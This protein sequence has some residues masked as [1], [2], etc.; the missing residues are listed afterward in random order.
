[1]AAL[2]FTRKAALMRIGT[3]TMTA[4]KNKPAAA[5]DHPEHLAERVRQLET[6]LRKS[7]RSLAD[8]LEREENYRTLFDSSNEAMVVFDPASEK[9]I[10]FTSQALRL[11][12]Y[13]PQEMLGRTM[14]DLLSGQPPCRQDCPRDG[15]CCISDEKPLIFETC[16]GRKNGDPL[17]LEVRLKRCLINRKNSL[18]MLLR[19]IGQRKQT[20]K[21]LRDSE[22]RYRTAFE[23]TG[24]AMFINEADMTLSM[25][26]SGFAKLTGYFKHE[27][28]GRM[29]WTQFV[30]PDDVRRLK[31]YHVNR[32]RNGDA[33]NELTCKLVDRQGNVKDMFLKVDLI[34]GT[35]RSIGSF[36]DITRIKQTEAILQDKEAQLRAILDSFDGL[37][38]VSSAD[39]RL[40]YINPGY[41]NLLGR[42]AT[43]ERCYR[44]LHGRDGVCPFCVQDQVQAGDTVSFE[45]HN[46]FDKRWYHS[47]NSPI[48]RVDGSL[49]LLALVTDINDRKEAEMALQ[50][51]A[52][53]LRKENTM[54]RSCIKERY[55]LGRIIGKSK[56]MQAVYEQIINA[57]ATNAN[58]IIYGE[59]GT[60]KELVARAIHDLSDRHDRSFVPVNS[61]AIPEKLL[62]S[63]FFG[64]KQGAFTGAVNDKPGY[65]DLADGG[66]LFLDELGEIELNLQV[67]L[68]RALESGVYTPVGDRFERKSDMRIIA[69]TNQDLQALV[70]RGRM[71]EDF[72]Y[73]INVIPIP[74]PP[75]RRRKD[76]LPLLVDHFL[77][78]HA[79]GANPP[80]LT[81]R[82]LDAL[83][84]YHWPGNVRELEN[85][86]LRYIS[87]RTFDPATIIG[88]NA[89]GRSK[90][91]PGHPAA[92]LK[93]QVETLERNL[94]SSTL[95]QHRWHKSN[96][97]AAL[98]IDRKTLAKKIQHYGLTEDAQS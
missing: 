33:P 84:D 63:E 44:A 78:L 79:K 1:V 15:S 27:I 23:N 70:R 52:R 45:V 59:S 18:V 6:A 47:V 73:R 82:I 14:Q 34:P 83:Y 58:V 90:P 72:F 89:A 68:L 5:A 17:W 10:D 4:K 26:N 39:F 87:M 38:Y 77:R 31:S 19:D 30:H 35:Q 41:R 42:D 22:A 95:K 98:G 96:V 93:E 46:P 53:N 66:T 37:I 32:R 8:A 7:K 3:C 29:K 36:I 60:G 21:T 94:I 55:K 9:I 24:T 40:E 54:L 67:K 65:L 64:Y 71:R 92:S 51:S 61:G 43:G 25:V 12:G 56:A 85:V 50:K 28:E 97:A 75:L 20:E 16:T 81:G 80:P 13:S 91:G 62:E 74:L 2:P 49:S 48:Q 11:Y 88:K 69:A 57:A 86:L 76:D